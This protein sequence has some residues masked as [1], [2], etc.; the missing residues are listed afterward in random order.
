MLVQKRRACDEH[1]GAIGKLAHRKIRGL[2]WRRAYAQR[3]IESLL[4]DI[5][6][7]I[8]HLGVD[9]HERMLSEKPREDFTHCAF[10]EADR[11]G[12][13]HQTLRS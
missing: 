4:D 9:T 7:P 8:G 11:T 6:A 5:D 1:R 3:Y 12:H 2:K 13:T 10:H